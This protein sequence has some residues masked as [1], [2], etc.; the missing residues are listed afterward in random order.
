MVPGT[1]W[2]GRCSTRSVRRPGEGRFAHARDCAGPARS[3]G[4]WRAAAAAA[5]G[6]GR[7]GEVER[8]L[9]RTR[10]PTQARTHA[11]VNACTR[12][13]TQA[14]ARTSS[15][16]HAHSHARTHTRTHAKCGGG[17]GEPR[18]P[19]CSR[20]GSLVVVYTHVGELTL[21]GEALFFHETLAGAFAQPPAGRPAVRQG[22]GDERPVARAVYNEMTALYNEMMRELGFQT[23]PGVNH[24]CALRNGSALRPPPPQAG[25]GA[26]VNMLG[27]KEIAGVCCRRFRMTLPACER[28]PSTA[29][30]TAWGGGCARSA[31]AP[32]PCDSSSPT[33]RPEA[34]PQ[35]L[36]PPRP[37]GPRP[38]HHRASSPRPA[39]SGAS[40]PPGARGP[41]TVGFQMLER[42]TSAQPLSHV[43]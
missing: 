6:A 17:Q 30:R 28:P 39:S 32:A 18:G 12:K 40:S 14:W 31:S 34:A 10:V 25:D 13:C 42:V 23:Y 3:L 41:V 22:D 33:S 15:H 20:Y 2:P 21:D 8:A 7:E 16:A 36:E 4:I 19:S 1:G 26:V 37:A 27:Y 29:T 38:R 11:C 43:R 9:A 35:G 5:A 24:H